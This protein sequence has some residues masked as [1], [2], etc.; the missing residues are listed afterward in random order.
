MSSWGPSLAGPPH[1]CLSIHGW[2]STRSSWAGTGVQ[3]QVLQFQ[4]SGVCSLG[5]W[6]CASTP[7]FSQD[8]CQTVPPCRKSAPSGRPALGSC[9]ITNLYAAASTLW[10]SAGTEN[11][12]SE[13]VWLGFCQHIKCL[14]LSYLRWH[15]V[16]QKKLIKS[17]AF[18]SWLRVILPNTSPV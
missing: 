5:L 4:V 14:G 8:V 12:L 10:G 17:K 1:F 18:V 13:C 15:P 9:Q 16:D 6:S 2:S 11:I 7:V 3:A